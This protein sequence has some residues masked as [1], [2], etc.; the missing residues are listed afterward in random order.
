MAKQKGINPIIGTID[1]F[2]YYQ[3]A[4]SGL[5][6]R[7][8]SSLDKNR[9]LTD[10]AFEPTMKESSE[11]GR[12]STAANLVRSTMKI[13]GYELSDTRIY[14]RLTGVLRRAIATDTM[15]E[16]GKRTL[17]GAD[18]SRLVGFDWNKHRQFDK[19]YKGELP[20]FSINAKSGLMEIDLPGINGPEHFDAVS[21]A[22]HVQFVLEGA[23]F[24][25]QLNEGTAVSDN[26]KWL[27]LKR[28]HPS[29]TMHATVAIKPGMRAVLGIGIRYGQEVNDKVYPLKDK[30]YVGFV[31]GMVL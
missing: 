9:L 16:K 27:Y 28:K 10:P 31:V 3:T 24:D 7:K 29:Q 2:T 11:F 20:K 18:L 21:S 13:G 4:E 12:G 5:L 19:L 6:V 30:Q 22:T 23:A 26:T 8:K 15:H 17:V 1:Q 25:F 14:S